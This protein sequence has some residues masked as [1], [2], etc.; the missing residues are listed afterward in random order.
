M[1]A[2]KYK[3]DGIYNTLMESYSDT[4]FMSALIAGSLATIGLAI[5]STSTV[6]ASTLI[7]PIGTFIIQANLS[8]FLKKYN[9]NFKGR[10]QSPWYIPL[11]LVVITT[12][13]I[14]YLIGKA[15]IFFNIHLFI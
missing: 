13:V 9:Y 6:V 14:S 12:L 11:L 10:K 7:S 3:L 2:I 5:N 15:M 1:A 8:R 4:P